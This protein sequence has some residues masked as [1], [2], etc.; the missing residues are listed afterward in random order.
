MERHRSDFSPAGYAA[1]PSPDVVASFA[2]IRNA[3]TDRPF[4]VAQ[5]G[6]S[7]DGRIAT[8]SGESRYINGEPALDHLHRLRAEVDAVLVGAG[9]VVADDPRLNVRRCAGRSPAR[10]VLDPRGR[11]AGAA[12]WLA[13]DGVRRLWVTGA[14]CNAPAGPAEHIALPCR[15]GHIDPRAILEALF[16]RGLRRVLVEGG[17][18]TIARF[19]GAGALDRLHVLVSPVIIGSGRAG[20]DLPPVPELARALRPKTDVY[21]LGGGDVLFDCD[22]AG[23][24]ED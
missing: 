15:E 21:I 14:A 5:I 7:L 20:F 24:R 10:V 23:G 17:A 1:G 19:L 3:R 11:L 12:K 13:E 18:R 6:Q 16:A 8:V 22:L 4:A 9:T 2:A